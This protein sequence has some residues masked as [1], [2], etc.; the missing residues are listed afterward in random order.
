[1]DRS[2]EDI[3]VIGIGLDIANVTSLKDYWLLFENNIDCIR[4]IPEHR[5]KQIDSYARL[6]LNDDESAEYFRGSFLE[7]ID[8]FDNEYFRISPREAQTMDPVQRILLQAIC[9]TFDDAGYTPEM[10]AGSQTGIYIGYTSGAIK[11]NYFTNIIFSYPELLRYSIVG[12]MSP[13]L[14]SRAAHFFDLHGPTMLI[15]TACSA[16]LVAVHEACESILNGSCSMAIAGGIKINLLPLILESMMIGIESNDGRTRAFDDYADGAGI[17][18]GV[19]CVLLKPL[20]EAEADGDNIYAVIKSTAI[21]NDGKSSSI[22]APNPASQARVILSAWEKAGIHPEQIDYIETHGTGTLLGD[23]VEFQGLSH[24]FEAFTDKKQFCALSSAKSNIGHLFECAGIA[25]FVKTVAALKFKRLPGMRNFLTPNKNIDF[26]DSPFYINT[27]AKDWEKPLNG[28]LRTCG[29]SAF[30]LSGTNCH[31]IVQEYT[32]AENKVDLLAWPLNVLCLSAKSEYSLRTLVQEY[33][34]YITNHDFEVNRVAA[35]A[36][37]YREHFPKRIA[38]VFTNKEDLLGKLQAINLKTPALWEGINGVMFNPN[39]EVGYGDTHKIGSALQ[40]CNEIYRNQ[41]G[42]AEYELLDMLQYLAQEYCNRSV[43]DWSK[44]YEGIKLPKMPLPQYPFQKTSAWVPVKE[45]MEKPWIKETARNTKASVE[46]KGFDENHF[47]YERGFVEA[48]MPSSRHYTSTCLFI[49][50]EDQADNDLLGY[51]KNHFL[52]VTCVAVNLEDAC[53]QGVSSYFSSRYQSIDLS[54]ITHILLAS[55]FYSQPPANSDELEAC[56]KFQM[57]SVIELYKQINQVQHHISII[58]LTDCG[59]SVTGSEKYLRPE[60]VCSFGLGKA[61]NR[62]YRNLHMYTLD[63]DRETDISTIIR[64][65]CNDDNQTNK[66]IVLYRENKRFIEGIREKDV[67][68]TNANI[69]RNEGVYL[70]TGGLG[71][72]GFETALEISKRAS[73]VSLVL[74]GRTKLEPEAEWNHILQVSTEGEC[75]E[76]IQRMLALRKYAKSVQYVQCDV[77]DEIAVQAL[78]EKIQHKYGKLNGIIHAAGVGGGTTLEQLDEERVM[79]ILNPKIIGTFVL[80]TLSRVFNPDFFVMYSSNSTFFSSSDLPDYIAGNMYLDA[81][82][83]YRKQSCNGLSLTINWATWLETGMSVKHNFTVDTLTRSI[84]TADAMAM[85]LAAMKG[86]SASMMIAQLNFKSKIALL[87]RKYPVVLSKNISSAL[88]KLSASNDMSSKAD[89]SSHLNAAAHNKGYSNTEKMISSICCKVLGYQDIDIEKNFFEL[90]ADS[91]MLTLILRELNEVYPDKLKVTD[92]FSFPTVKTLSQYVASIVVDSDT[93][94]E[95]GATDHR[96]G[97]HFSDELSQSDEDEEYDYDG[98][99]IIGVGLDL[100]NAGD[101]QSFWEILTNG[102]NVVRDIPDS[103][104]FDITRHLKYQGMLD[105]DLRFRKMG[106]LDH[107]NQFDYSFFGISPREASI[108]DPVN[109]L[110]LQCSAKAIDDSGYGRSGVKGTNTAIFLGYSASNCNTYSRLLYETDQTLF[111][112]SL[113]VNQVS[114]AA[115]RVAY[116]YDLKGPSMVIDTACSS[117]LV[118]LHMACEEIRQGKSSMALAGGA[119]I[120]HMPLDNGSDVGFESQESVTRAFSQ[121]SSGSAV[122]E[123]VG[124]VMLKSLRQAIED[125]D[126]IYAVIRGSAI[127]QDGSS[128]GIAAPNFQAQSEAIQ[129]AW[130]QAGVS[131]ED[132]TYI[133]AHGT[134]TQLGD[135]IEV[136]GIKNAF[137]V[138]TNRKQVC[139]IGS[140]KTNLGHANEAAGMCGIF[141]LIGILQHKQIPASLYFKSPNTNIDFVDTPLYVVDQKMPLKEIRGRYLVG[142]SGFGMSG[143]NAHVVLENAPN[144]RKIKHIDNEVPYIFAASAKSKESL[145]HLIAGYRDYAATLDEAQIVDFC[146]NLTLGR[147]HYNYRF[148]FAAKSRDDMLAKLEQVL[149]SEE[150]NTG[151]GYYLGQYSIVSE[152]K[153]SRNPHEITIN[154]QLNLT[155]ECDTILQA[156]YNKD[157]NKLMALYVKGAEVKWFNIYSGSYNKMHLPVYVFEKNNCWYS[158]PEND[159]Q[160]D[161]LDSYFHAKTWVRMDNDKSLDIKDDA[162]T[163]IIYDS[164]NYDSKFTEAVEAKC[165][166]VISVIT[167]DEGEYIADG[168]MIRMPANEGCYQRLFEEL[169]GKRVEHIIHRRSIIKEQVKDV[170]RIYDSLERGFFDLISMFKGLAKAHVEQDIAICILS[171]LAYGIHHNEPFTLPHQAVTLGLGKVI[172]Q[173]NPTISCRAIDMDMNTSHKLIAEEVFADHNIYLVGFRNNE[174]YVEEF[175]DV[176]IETVIYNRFKPGGVYLVTGGTD[177]LGLE[178]AKYISENEKCNIILMSRSGFVDEALWPEYEN[179]EEYASRI[180]VMKEIKSNDCQLDIFACDVC[181]YEDL[182]NVLQTI[183]NKFGRIDGIFH[184]AGI[185]GAGYILRKEKESY[186]SVMAPKI[187]GTWNLDHLTIEDHLDF[188]VLYSSGV[189]DGGEAGQ[190]D[191]LGANAFLDAYTD[192]RSAQNRTTYTINWCSWK[193]TGMSYRYGVNVDSITK[194][195]STKEAIQALDTFIRGYEHKRVMIGQYNINENFFALMQHT[196]NHL[197]PSFHEKVKLNSSNANLDNERINLSN[198]LRDFAQIRKGR[199]VFIPKSEKV[200]SR[201]E[202]VKDFKLE[203]DPA[204]QYS[205]TEREVARVYSGILGYENLNVYDNFFEMGGDSVMLAAMHDMLDE[206]YPDIIRVAFLFE[207]CSIRSLAGF[208]D[209]KTKKEQAKAEIERHDHVVAAEDEDD[210][211]YFDLS[212]PQAR[213][214]YESRLRKGEFV[215]NNPFFINVS[216]IDDNELEK[217]LEALVMQHE[218][219]RT[220]FKVVN[221]KLVQYIDQEVPVKVHYIPVAQDTEINYCDYLKEFKLSESPLFKLTVFKYPDQKI[222]FFDVHHILMDGFSSSLIQKDFS[223]LVAQ[224]TIESRSSYRRYVDFEKEFFLSDEYK[225]MKEYWQHRLSGFDFS[226]PLEHISKPTGLTGSKSIVKQ[227]PD[228]ILSEVSRVAREHQTTIFNVLISSLALSLSQACEV[229]DIAILTTVLNRYESE[230]NSILGVFTNLIP[231]RFQVDRNQPI[232]HCLTEVMKNQFGD[233]KNQYYQ[234]H[235][236]IGDFKKEKAEFHLYFNFEDTSMKKVYGDDIPFNSPTPLFDLDINIKKRNEHYELVAIYKANKYQHD[237]IESLLQIYEDILQLIT[238]KC[239]VGKS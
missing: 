145:R 202:S 188:M 200:R 7:H 112:D 215:Y 196:R 160:P 233:I 61:F 172:E 5:Q 173:E 87:M 94:M 36:N 83:S 59:F 122:A 106:Y 71:G 146:Y 151:E 62:E 75:A 29:I 64:E 225:S 224:K 177:G 162:Y 209:S 187:I 119:F 25:S 56:I 24:A 14:P 66:D 13:M 68:E 42:F 67:S 38:I 37:L 125:H 76:R 155:N 32:G 157:W 121:D 123:G 236:L 63:V 235:D 210:K 54:Q 117:S 108:I 138:F 105:E 234:Y 213:I 231:M 195:M 161:H 191:Y 3:A 43:V 60:N 156:D 50:R 218:M 150:L 23:P 174:R 65:I 79:G 181:D 17:G 220:S 153:P 136:A 35:C 33:E 113:P 88:D 16:S 51:L 139:G 142:I 163:L 12:N 164:T 15:D 197:A 230:F 86:G 11:D 133:E 149:K 109:R 111:N 143:T 90:G 18:E 154:E 165:R 158:I 39:A 52:N 20:K 168:S 179:K 31:V 216:G 186:L 101:L 175:S 82:S 222:L 22:T 110:F 72:I 77:S 237:D 57:F 203:G 104:A 107:I 206:M 131:A 137:E 4:E 93:S 19:A 84:R 198:G 126:D 134:G 53:K 34:T 92:M 48:Q 219:L 204:N 44:L 97:S 239:Q 2:V 140:I 95:E 78:M 167:Y 190:S 238:E 226:N 189:T 98:V 21:N 80:D 114:M 232:H 10:L 185:S 193:E 74:L 1:M 227:L 129:L 183:R 41:E 27:S 8:Q 169:T 89:A 214:Y 171:N 135:P 102:V 69:L 184:S 211:P 103:R 115:S 9:H 180:A 148:A 120:A 132:I 58:Y 152:S 166:N 228:A 73:D 127:N 128:F 178:T 205:E 217:L 99:A 144:Q 47:F 223:D 229:S 30:G 26:C 46:S 70:I 221:N 207:Y 176:E 116:V 100:P 124:V 194:A 45:S 130:K 81:Y 182:D 55:D 199:I 208:I 49:Y 40:R 118:T 212:S 159:H 96:G 141:K 201:L 147:S 28:K 192:F 85:L 91:I 6:Y 170:D